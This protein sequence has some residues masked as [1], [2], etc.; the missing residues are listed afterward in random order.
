MKDYINWLNQEKEGILTSNII[1]KA[2]M[3]HYYLTEIHPFGD[4]NGRTARAVEAMVLYANGINPYCFWSLANFWSANRNEYI[5]HLGNIRETCNPL[6]LL[7]W[8]AQGYLREIKRIKERVLTK[9]KQL[10]LQ[11]Y[12]RYLSDTKSQQPSSKKINQR[13]RGIL[14][15][16]TQ[17]GKISFNKLR[18]SPEYKSLY[19]KVSN[20]T[21]SRDFSKMKSLRLIRFSDTEGQTFIEPNYEILEGLQY[22]V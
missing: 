12:V 3:A 9:V 15:L 5:F 1:A 22:N 13:I 7:I 16:L 6:D 10:M 17:S 14:F 8:G 2:I 11:D 19:H 20:M 21:Q 4:G 18:S